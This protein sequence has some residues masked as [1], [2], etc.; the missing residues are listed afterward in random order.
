MVR[1]SILFNHHQSNFF[2]LL[3]FCHALCSQTDFLDFYTKIR[4]SGLTKKELRRTSL[5]KLISDIT[6]KKSSGKKRIAI[7]DRLSASS[8]KEGM[9]AMCLHIQKCHTLKGRIKTKYFFVVS[10]CF[11][12]SLVRCV[13]VCAGNK[14]E[15]LTSKWYY[16]KC[17]QWPVTVRRRRRT[18]K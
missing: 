3:S 15:L 10:T 14:I 13:C 4:L 12:R 6:I 7:V 16:S 2:L 18:K 9:P 17:I 5:F 11:C 8:S 1:D